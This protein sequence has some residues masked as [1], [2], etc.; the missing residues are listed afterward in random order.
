MTQPIMAPKISNDKLMKIIEDVKQ[1]T[2]EQFQEST[3]QFTAKAHGSSVPPMHPREHSQDTTYQ[4]EREGREGII[5]VSLRNDHS[6]H[7]PESFSSD[8]LQTTQIQ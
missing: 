6:Q 8:R 2:A 1:D 5:S 7:P 3:L 4:E